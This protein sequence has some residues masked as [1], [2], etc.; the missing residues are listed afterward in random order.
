MQVQGGSDFQTV[1]AEVRLSTLSRFGQAGDLIKIHPTRDWTN[2]RMAGDRSIAGYLC[3][4]G[5]S[6][7]EMV[8]VKSMHCRTQSNRQLDRHGDTVLEGEITQAREAAQLRLAPG[9]RLGLGPPHETGCSSKKRP[10]DSSSEKRQQLT[11]CVSDSE[12]FVAASA[13]RGIIIICYG[14]LFRSGATAS[15]TTRV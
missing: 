15:G 3:G 11:V 14:L 12:S 6:I 2:P 5:R 4:L 9:H 7:L 10:F 1:R 8:A 13:C